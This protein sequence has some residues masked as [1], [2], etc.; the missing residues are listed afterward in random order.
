MPKKP[1]DLSLV[2]LYE[3][4]KKAPVPKLSHINI[5]YTVYEHTDIRKTTANQGA[6]YE[7]KSGAVWR[8]WITAEISHDALLAELAKPAAKRRVWV[9][10]ETDA[11]LRQC[12]RKV[13]ERMGWEKDACQ[14]PAWA[15][16]R[17]ALGYGAEP[18]PKKK[19]ALPA[20]PK[21]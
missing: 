18:P 7:T 9:A 19:A 10:D 21:G 14:N 5:S 12:A 16:I 17:D 20:G 13:F 3:T 15:D 8:I 6:I 4:L 2:W 1:Q 11:D